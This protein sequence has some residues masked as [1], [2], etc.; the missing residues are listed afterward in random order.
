MII[1]MTK[2]KNNYIVEIKYKNEKKMKIKRRKKILI[3]LIIEELISTVQN[4]M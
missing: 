4:N 2:N 1:E 3:T